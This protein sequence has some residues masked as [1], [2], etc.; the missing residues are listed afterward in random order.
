MASNPIQFQPGMSLPD[1]LRYFG[2]EARCE[3]ALA[4]VRWP[5]GFICPACATAPHCLVQR[6]RRRLYQCN[7][8][9][10]QSSLTA[11]TLF[12]ST[13]L[14]LTTWF[15]AIYLISQAKTGL[16]ALALKRQIGVS[17]PTAWLMHHKIMRTMADST[18]RERLSGH[19]QLDDAY[20]GG[21]VTG[22]KAG[23][24]SPNKIPFVAAVALNEKGRP[25]H[26]KLSPLPAFSRQAIAQWAQAH[27]SPGT[28]VS[29]DGLA[30]FAGVTEAGCTHSPFVVGQLK[31]RELPQFKW[32][33]TILGNLK[34]SLSGAH[35]AFKFRKYAA[36]YLGAFA[37]RFNHRF[38]LADLV[39]RLLV[40]TATTPASP[41]RI[42][43]KA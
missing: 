37:Y 12:A 39:I 29:S 42:I 35:H 9:R 26:L 16:S 33:N 23:R 17:Y 14:P 25:T 7:A 20:L 15:L 18:A 21:E 6:D 1:F 5:H 24:G 3:D 32:V 13:K 43:R 34:T 36:M 10:H 4:R 19:V 11:G 8:C 41:L 22:A 30:C 31:P 28:L 2:D 27:L 38:D 40:E